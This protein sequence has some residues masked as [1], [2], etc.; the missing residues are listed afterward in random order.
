MKIS[1]NVFSLAISFI[2]LCFFS[3][4]FAAYANEPPVFIGSR[5]ELMVDNYLIEKMDDTLDLRLHK[6]TPREI[7]MVHDAP[8]EGSGT[9]YHT[10]FRDGDLYR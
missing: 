2:F 7:V 5:S 10:V 1:G 8:W 3:P 6:P 9:G 4:F